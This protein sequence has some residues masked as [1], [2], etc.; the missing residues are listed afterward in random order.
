MKAASIP[1]LPTRNVGFQQ[2]NVVPTL[3]ISEFGMISY[4]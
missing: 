4:A 3:R 2:S 1:P